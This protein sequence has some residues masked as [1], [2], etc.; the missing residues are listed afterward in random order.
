MRANVINS[1]QSITSVY[2]RMTALTSLTLFGL[3][4]NRNFATNDRLVP[5]NLHT[6]SSKL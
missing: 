1:D 5:T 4:L 6:F 3:E 2:F